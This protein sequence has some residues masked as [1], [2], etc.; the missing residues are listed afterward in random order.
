[1]A[2]GPH[3]RASARALTRRLLALPAPP[4]AIFA[5][6]DDQ[7]L[8]VLEAA[9]AEPEPVRVPDQLSVVGFDDV[10]VAR[11]ARLTTVAQPLE[12][13]GALAAELL[14]DALMGGSPPRSRE[15]SC[16]ASSSFV[17]RPQRHTGLKRVA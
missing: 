7:A 8:G 10:E 12:A 5:A 3:G 13:S 9:A 14:L 11:Y 15:L 6:S 16:P 4:T 17:T 2:T 1:V